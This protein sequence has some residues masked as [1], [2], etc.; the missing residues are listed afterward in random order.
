MADPSTGTY[1]LWRNHRGGVKDSKETK[2][3]QPRLVGLWEEMC[4][5]PRVWGLNPIS[6]SSSAQDQDN[7]QASP[8]SKQPTYSSQTTWP[9][10]VASPESTTQTEPSFLIF[11]PCQLLHKIDKPPSPVNIQHACAPTSLKKSSTPSWISQL[12]LQLLIGSCKP[13]R[14]SPAR[15]HPRHGQPQSFSQMTSQLGQRSLA[16]DRRC[17]CGRDSVS[18][19]LSGKSA[20]NARRS[21]YD[22]NLSPGAPLQQPS[23]LLWKPFLRTQQDMRS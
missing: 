20:V 17:P 11:G 22:F 1:P 2:F 13:G 23:V 5:E 4:L 10:N 14:S 19:V 3:L 15:Q 16:G 8:R 12:L 7:F 18:L 6:S 21:A 9:R